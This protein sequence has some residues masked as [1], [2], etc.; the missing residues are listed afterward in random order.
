[1]GEVV[2]AVRMAVFVLPIFVSTF[3]PI[4]KGIFTNFSLVFCFN[5]QIPI[6]PLPDTI[7]LIRFR[8]LLQANSPIYRFYTHPT[9]EEL[10]S[11]SAGLHL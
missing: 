8:S 4:V 2:Q 1:M 3:L 6:T 11:C 9:F 10:P 7:P 5:Q